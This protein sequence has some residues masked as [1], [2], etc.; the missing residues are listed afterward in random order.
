M[1]LT[2]W[3]PFQTKCLSGESWSVQGAHGI[4]CLKLIPAKVVHLPKGKKGWNM[5]F[6]ITIT[7]SSAKKHRAPHVWVRSGKAWLGRN[8]DAA[9]YQQGNEWNELQ[10]KGDS[11]PQGQQ[12]RI[13]WAYLNSISNKQELFKH[14]KHARDVY[15]LLYIRFLLNICKLNLPENLLWFWGPHPPSKSQHLSSTASG[16]TLL[17]HEKTCSGWQLFSPPSMNA[18]KAQNTLS[19]TN[20]KRI[21]TEQPCKN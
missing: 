12:A 10:N 7:S 8:G 16:T 9:V 1:P 2:T 6:R 3:I 4:V 20:P 15:S 18:T 11:C 21:Q 19:T 17:R 14:D 13:I 5:A